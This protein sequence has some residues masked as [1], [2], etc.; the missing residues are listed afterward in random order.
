[1]AT[2][3]DKPRG[4]PVF[5][6]GASVLDQVLADAPWRAGIGWPSGFE[7]GIAHRL[8]TSTSGALL[9]GDS[10]EE[11]ARLRDWF[12]GGRLRK[13]YRF[14]AGKDVGWDTNTCERRIGHDPR[15]KGRMIVER[16]PSMAHRG[17]WYEASTAFRRLDDR[18]W[19]A[20]ITTG[21]T[22]QIRVHAAF[23]RLALLGD[24][25]YGGGDTGDGF[26]LHHAGLEGP[27]G[28][29]TAAVPLPA[30]AGGRAV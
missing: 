14:V 23:V 29:R 24:R 3:V 9:L 4:V 22:H 8:D 25:V 11:L 16:G 20:V 26:F 18:L 28:F 27:G 15:R 19:E 10:L 30:W 6:P 5:P 17:R 1:M 21:V 7:G 13:T 2:T 12:S